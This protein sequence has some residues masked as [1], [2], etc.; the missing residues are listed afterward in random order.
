MPGNTKR[1]EDL[2]RDEDIAQMKVDVIEFYKETGMK[3]AAA[4]FVGR[5]IQTV[6]DWEAAD[7]QFR[8][9]M[10]RAKARFAKSN[11]HKIRLDNLYANLYPDDFKPPTQTVD[12]K[13][14]TIEGQS[15]EDL[16]AE[17]NRLGLDT[18]PY[19]SLLTGSPDPGAAT[20]DQ[21]QERA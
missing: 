9:D 2:S 16:L 11:K 6:Q 19:E 20:Q 4:N 3:T 14:T 10:L 21:S 1:N 17:A 12:T 13:V 5:S 15:A 7:E 18:T 8:D